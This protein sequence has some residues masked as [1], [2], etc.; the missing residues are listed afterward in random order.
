M[1]IG[2]KEAGLGWKA[3]LRGS[4]STA[5]AVCFTL[6]AGSAAARAPAVVVSH[7]PLGLAAPGCS[8]R[9]R[10]PLQQRFLV[11]TRAEAGNDLLKD[12]ALR[13]GQGVGGPYLLCSI[14]E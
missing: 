10:P 4:A 9:P 2:G 12:L 3:F 6:V 8:L 13:G 14:N 1:Q 11:V 7:R 5:F